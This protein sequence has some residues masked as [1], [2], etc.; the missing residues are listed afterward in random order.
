[1]CHNKSGGFKMQKAT[2]L[3]LR[4]KMGSLVKKLQETGEPILLEKDRKPVAVIISLED[5]KRRFVDID[6]D[7]RRRE[8]IDEIKKARIKLPK[9]VNSLDIITAIRSGN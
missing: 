9:N 1:M 3:E 7:I 5:Y 4:Q 8:I 6:A 2:A